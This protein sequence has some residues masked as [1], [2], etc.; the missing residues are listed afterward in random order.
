MTHANT[1]QGT[2]KVI[3]DRASRSQP[4]STGRSLDNLKIP[5]YR[6]GTPHFT[7][8]GSAV[9]HSSINTGSSLRNPP[10]PPDARQQQHSHADQHQAQN[11]TA[12]SVE[13]PTTSGHRFNSSTLKR[14]LHKVQ[15]RDEA[16]P[17]HQTPPNVVT[18]KRSIVKASQEA[19]VRI[20]STT[21]Q[22][23][24]ASIPQLIIQV[25]SPKLL[26]YDLLSDF[27]LTYRLFMTSHDLATRLIERLHNAIRSSDEYSR[28]VRVRTFVA[29]RHWILNYFVDDFVAN[30]DLRS[31]F[32]ALVNDLCRGLKRDA[33]EQVGDLRI[34]AELKKCWRHTCA[35]FWDV[36]LQRD[37]ESGDEDIFPGG[38]L[39][40]RSIPDNGYEEKLGNT[41]SQLVLPDESLPRDTSP[42]SILAGPDFA[43]NQTSK[44]GSMTISSA[45]ST[46]GLPPEERQSLQVMSCSIPAPIFSSHRHERNPSFGPRPVPAIGGLQ[47]QSTKPPSTG[48]NPRKHHNRSGSFSDALRD[49]RAPLPTHKGEI[50]EPTPVPIAL[51]GSLVRGATIS[52]I[53]PYVESVVPGTPVDEST[54]KFQ[55]HAQDRDNDQRGREFHSSNP[56]VRRFIG[57][58]RR[59][60]SVKSAGQRTYS[61]SPRRHSP[62]RD[63]MANS[64]FR[65]PLRRE[66]SAQK[67]K[68]VGGR[69]ALRIDLLAA[70]VSEAFKLAVQEVREAQEA[71]QNPS[72]LQSTE[73][74]HATQPAAHDVPTL[75]VPRPGEKGESVTTGS[76]SI[77]IMDDTNGQ[78]TPRPDLQPPDD[79]FGQVHSQISST[80]PDQDGLQSVPIFLDQGQAESGALHSEPNDGSENSFVRLGSEAHTEDQRSSMPSVQPGDFPETPNATDRHMKDS[81]TRGTSSSSHDH[82]FEV[83]T[84]MT[85]DTQTSTNDPF[86]LERAPV[87]QLRR[88][89]G[90]NLKA[91]NHVHSLDDHSQAQLTQAMDNAL[92]VPEIPP[93][94]SS[95]NAKELQR[96]PTQAENTEGSKVHQGPTHQ[97]VRQ[98]FER[99]VAKL[100]Q[101]PDLEENDE[102]VESAL[103]KLEGRG[104]SAMSEPPPGFLVEIAGG[105]GGLGIREEQADFQQA[106]QQ[107]RTKRQHREDEL[108]EVDVADSAQQVPR[109][110]GHPHIIVHSKPLSIAGSTN[111]QSSIPLLE[112]GASQPPKPNM[113]PAI[114]VERDSQS[115]CDE[116]SEA[117]HESQQTATTTLPGSENSYEMIEH[118]EGLRKARAGKKPARSSQAHR[119]FLLNDNESLSELSSP[120]AEDF[121]DQGGLHSPGMHSFFED[122]AESGRDTPRQAHSEELPRRSSS[123]LPLERPGNPLADSPKDE[124]QVDPACVPG[125]RPVTRDGTGANEYGKPK[126]A[127]N[128]L[129]TKHARQTPLTHSPAA[130]HLPFI[131]AYDSLVV[132]QQFTVIE[133][134][135]L[136]EIDWRDLID[137]RWNQS[138]TAYYNWVDYLRS[139]SGSDPPH[140][141]PAVLR[142][143]VDICIARFNLVVRWVKSEVVL[144]QDMHERAAT[145]I[146]F[147]HI[148][149][150]A[151]QL[152]NWAT[153]YQIA[154]ALVSADLSR[155]KQTWATVPEEEKSTLARLE[156]LIMPKRNFHNLRIEIETATSTW[157]HGGEGGC[158]PFIGVYTHDLIYNAQKPAKV[159]A[160]PRAAMEDTSSTDVEEEPATLINFE[161][162]HT[163]AAIVKNLLRLIEASSKYT[164]QPDNEVTSRCLWI[165]ALHDAEVTRRSKELEPF[166]RSSA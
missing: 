76:R 36:P 14:N 85:E 67:R 115:Q 27:F 88:L 126:S 47:K 87:R 99:E 131:L 26:D 15:S 138:A 57:S 58:V 19:D 130:T 154:M 11:A 158:V 50:E 83:A 29:L 63:R 139:N 43:F 102:G 78:V 24:A 53:S 25:T 153:M 101:L 28:I 35:L 81:I 136:C 147:I 132:A 34:L 3:I 146:K 143:G 108:V 103:R 157:T 59:A 68:L 107:D 111:T 73:G 20:S 44:L 145:I 65:T 127:E 46:R 48:E 74:Q 77:V 98:S 90:G 114:V 2:I 95:N 80:R 105:A 32:C 156:E 106:P 164:F 137:L 135:A 96:P 165:G 121:S 6:L 91:A 69:A 12:P 84:T 41:G 162:H 8:K 159:R 71:L 110:S 113:S 16:L 61:L 89:P 79:P 134:D 56:G 128:L 38:I 33:P 93:R 30:L 60:L 117:D 72:H 163:A 119:S 120:T 161:R 123:P 142:P 148:A 155:L 22:L 23:L 37:L 7:D 125:S 40:S 75:Q 104:Q 94:R 124:N 100:A 62:D 160:R 21:G 52:P 31:R 39:G 86:H 54:P 97:P 141:H 122:E 49:D 55:A 9:L 1:P 166:E 133:R 70:E 118:D 5:H 152:R 109:P 151:R 42:S 144:T 18:L 116:K 4:P 13:R 129:F 51:P 149:Q 45:S 64:P 10:L 140:T 92:H 17:P 150:H 82:S 112:R 66:P